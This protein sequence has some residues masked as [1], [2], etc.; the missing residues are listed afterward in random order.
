MAH[1]FIFSEI[2]KT[3][4]LYHLRSFIIIIIIWRIMIIMLLWYVNI[5]YLVKFVKQ[6]KNIHKIYT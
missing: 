5:V 2:K 1:K 6:L 3:Y 4:V